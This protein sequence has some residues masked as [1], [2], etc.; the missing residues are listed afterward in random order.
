MKKW[1]RE[2]G[3]KWSKIAPNILDLKTI[4]LL[5]SAMPTQAI[6]TFILLPTGSVSIR[7]PFP[8]PTK[9]DFQVCTDDRIRVT[10]R[11]EIRLK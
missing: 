1:K 8:I 3:L 7:R 4:N 9:M 2:P 10:K 6:N 11:K 5:Q